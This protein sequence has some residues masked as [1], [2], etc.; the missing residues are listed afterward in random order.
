[1]VSVG[2]PYWG[3]GRWYA[4]WLESRLGGEGDA[5]AVRLANASEEAAGAGRIA[6][7][8]LIGSPGGPLR[9]SVPLVGGASALKR[10]GS[11]RL[12]VSGH[13]N[14]SHVHMSAFSTAYSRTPFWIHYHP[15]LLRIYDSPQ[16]KPLDLLCAGIHDFVR[17]VLFPDSLIESLRVRIA[18]PDIRD[19]LAKTAAERAAGTD[20]TLSVID[21]MMRFGPE[22]IFVLLQTFFLRKLF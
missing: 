21:L 8:T 5:G 19:L 10:A 2:L 13:G 3:S 12:I 22:A 20:M 7:R 17:S 15:A 18:D 6:T 1:M 9:L 14:W 16:D 4:S 11:S